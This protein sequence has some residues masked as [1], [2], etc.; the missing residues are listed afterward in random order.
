M[1]DQPKNTYHP[2]YIKLTFILAMLSLIV[3]GMVVAKAVLIPL[4]FAVFFAVL[5]SP[6][7]GKLEDWRVPRVVAALLSLLL[8]I[9]VLVI[10]GIFFYTQIVGLADD[11]SLVEE[12][13]RSLLLQFEDVAG[14][15]VDVDLGELVSTIPQNMIG[16]VTDNVES[17]SRGVLSAASTLT[18][19][20]IIPVYVVLFLLFRDFL[21]EFIIRAFSYGDEARM[22]RLIDKVKSVVQNYI[23]GMLIVIL[24][25]AVLN[26]T[27]LWAF[28][29]RHAL[30]FGVFAAMLN[31]IPFVGPL[32]GS[33]LPI[34]YALLTMD[35]LLIPLFVLLGFYIIQ[36]FE[37]NLFTPSIVG[38]QVSLNPLVTL[39]A[40]FVGAQIWGLVGMI[41]FIPASAVLKVIFDEFDSLKPYGF[42]LGKADQSHRK[43]KSKL[44]LKVQDISERFSERANKMISDTKTEQEQKKQQEQKNTEG[45]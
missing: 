11:A 40:I 38:R 29:V 34:F 9:G 23:L 6:L 26:S 31:I 37:S 14:A 17:L 35:S 7:C 20:F 19:F 44:A 22:Q 36:L 32:I 10:T 27:M 25:L 43:R 13:I 33:V 15:Y 18:T 5:L 42:L 41:L 2:W 28:G 24:I 4:F 21:K 3:Y 12:R 1:T 16:Y 30:F 8:G 45:P 39:V